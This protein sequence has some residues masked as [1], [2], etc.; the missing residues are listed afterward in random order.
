MAPAIMGTVKK[1]HE[2]VKTGHF[3]DPDYQLEYQDDLRQF[4]IPIEE[5]LNILSEYDDDEDDD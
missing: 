4:N 2:Q 1:M 5:A 3:D